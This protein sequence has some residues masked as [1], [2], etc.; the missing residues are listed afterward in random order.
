MAQGSQSGEQRVRSRFPDELKAIRSRGEGYL[1][2]VIDADQHTAADRL[3]QLDEECEKRGVARRT[4]EDRAIVVVPRRNVETWFEYLD[5]QKVDEDTKYPKR[6]KGKDHRRLADA[7][8]DTCHERQRLPKS[9]PPSLTES[10]A[11][12]ERLKRDQSR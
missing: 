5:G 2:V 6:F 9:A 1:V 3:G 12:Y 11:E 10:C 4:P 8:Y 7:L